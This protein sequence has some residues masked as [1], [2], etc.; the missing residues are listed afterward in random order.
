M[1]GGKAFFP[2]CSFFSSI[3]PSFF[4]DS[5]F[6]SWWPLFLKIVGFKVFFFSLQLISTEQVGRE[7]SSRL[8]FSSTL[9]PNFGSCLRFLWFQFY[10][11]VCLSTFFCRI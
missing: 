11:F 4:S 5:E 7:I 3:V 6:V 1:E 2:S 8:F 9:F 10:F